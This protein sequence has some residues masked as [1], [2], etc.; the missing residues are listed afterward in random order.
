MAEETG[1]IFTRLKEA[2]ASKWTAAGNWFSSLRGG[3]A[4]DAAAAAPDANPPAGG[5]GRMAEAASNLT[6]QAQRVI[7]TMTDKTENVAQ[8]IGQRMPDGIKNAIGSAQD[9]LAQMTQNVNPD[10]IHK[11][12]KGGIYVTS[13]GLGA[14]GVRRIASKD[15]EGKRSIGQV[16]LGVAEVAAAVGGGFVANELLR[17]NGAAKS[18]QQQER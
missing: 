7:S 15:A 1:N 14:D 10:T 13:I 17:R 2:T 9:R 11:V 16:A 5:Q 18:S 6:G 8:T 4:A 3:N 12:K